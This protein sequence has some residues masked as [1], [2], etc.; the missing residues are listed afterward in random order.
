MRI[1]PYA[2]PWNR[3]AHYRVLPT[4]EP[5]Y[6]DKAKPN[7]LAP[8][9]YVRRLSRF[10]RR[11]LVSLLVTTVV[12]CLLLALATIGVRPPTRRYLRHNTLTET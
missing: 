7:S 2:M 12:L 9:T 10:P 8:G 4:D 1:L 5:I 3:Q 6:T 11:R